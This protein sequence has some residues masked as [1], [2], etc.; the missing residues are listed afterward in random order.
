M[1]QRPQPFI[2]ATNANAT[3]TLATKTTHLKYFQQ[4]L[5]TQEIDGSLTGLVRRAKDDKDDDAFTFLNDVTTYQNFGGY[6][7]DMAGAT[8]LLAVQSSQGGKPP[9][10]RAKK[11]A[12]PN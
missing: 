2:P 11:R 10:Q 1:S 12:R 8:A 6:L 3:T 7:I 5:A 9:R 4:F